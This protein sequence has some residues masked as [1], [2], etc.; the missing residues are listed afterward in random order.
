MSDLI[1]EIKEKQRARTRSTIFTTII[2][3]LC[4]VLVIALSVKGDKD[5][6]RQMNTNGGVVGIANLSSHKVDVQLF[7]HDG[8]TLSHTLT[9]RDQ[10]IIQDSMSKKEVS[11]FP[12]VNWLDSGY[13]LFDDTLLLRHY[14][15]SYME[16]SYDAH[17]ITGSEHWW[18][19]S[20]I[21]RRPSRY[22][23]AIYRP[24]RIYKITDKDFQNALEANKPK[25]FITEEEVFHMTR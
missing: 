6:Q 1:E 16:A 8:T 11:D 13:L 3:F 21:A 17:C 12:P 20:L 2:L 18:Y 10:W 23:P 14:A 7:L 9:P 5:R 25:T 22:H 15:H 4:A 19:E 24:S